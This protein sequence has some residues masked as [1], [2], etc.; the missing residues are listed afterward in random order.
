M[1]YSNKLYITCFVDVEHFFITNCTDF[2]IECLYIFTLNDM[3]ININTNKQKTA[4]SNALSEQTHIKCLP[5]ILS[6]MSGT[7]LF[8]IKNVR[9]INSH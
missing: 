5:N 1:F 6:D 9:L 7:G 4:K 8:I 2:F 3:A